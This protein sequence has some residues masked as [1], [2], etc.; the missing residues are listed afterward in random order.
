MTSGLNHEFHELHEPCPEDRR[1][2]MS[3]V[4]TERAVRFVQFVVPVV[5]SGGCA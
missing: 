5:S 2:S 1:P 4:C 3:R